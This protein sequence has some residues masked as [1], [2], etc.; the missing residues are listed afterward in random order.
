MGFNN[1]SH[2]ALLPAILDQ[3]NG[4]ERKAKHF[5]SYNH[6]QGNCRLCLTITQGKDPRLKLHPLSESANHYELVTASRNCDGM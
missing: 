6:A 4:A 3:E 5:L 1:G 2:I